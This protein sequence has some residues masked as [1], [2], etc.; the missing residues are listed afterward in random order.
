MWTQPLWWY[1]HFSVRQ[2]YL[3][4]NATTLVDPA[5]FEAMTPFYLEDYGNAS[6]IHALG[7]KARA[8]VED[9]RSQVADLIGAET[10]AI[11]F[12]SGGTESDNTAL[13]GVAMALRSK[14][15]H[16]ITT[17]IEHSAILHTC[18]QLEEEGF[19]VTYLPVDRLG[20]LSLDRLREAIDED[21]ILISVM[22]ANNEIGIIE[23]LKKMAVLAR[24]RGVL[25][26]TDAVQTVGKIA[27]DVGDLGVDL[28]SLSAHKFH[29]PKGVGALYVRGDVAMF[30]LL[31][32]GSHERS[33]RA[34]TLNVPG[35]VGLG[36]TCELAK[37]SLEDFGTRVRG[38][39]D[40][41]EKGIIEGIPDA[42]VNGSTTE[43]VPH[44][45]NISFRLIEGE[46]LLIALDFQGV[47]VSTGSAC[48]SGTVEPSHVLTALGGDRNRQKSAI[49]FSLGRVNND[50]DIDYVLG[51]LPKMVEKM[52]QVSPIYRTV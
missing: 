19:R 12:T 51:I 5:V 4:N 8:A 38:L 36:K 29:G 11:V 39:R 20:L 13:R 33:R 48:S 15:S 34:G 42:F 52:R 45:S 35:I 7:Q 16:I 46:A 6:S 17:T 3:D 44:L 21:T 25:F 2:V 10:G 24:E 18:R 9:A 50:E 1:D 37:A 41:L 30:P 27:L 28:L 22:H 47:A 32:G 14:G 43:R 23:P 31:H 40:K 26:H 49:R